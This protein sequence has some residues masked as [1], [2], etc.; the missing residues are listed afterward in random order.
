V[1]I[2]LGMMVMGL[3]V[4]AYMGANRARSLAVGGNMLKISGQASLSQLYAQLQQSRHIYDRG[5]ATD[6]YLAL[7][8]ITGYLAGA[9]LSPG[10]Q[11]TPTSEV[12][13]P[14]IKPN[15]SFEAYLDDGTGV[16]GG[17]ALTTMNGS[18][19]QAS[20]GNALFFLAKDGTIKV[21]ETGT[22]YQQTAFNSSYYAFHTYRFHYYFLVH[23]QLPLRAPNVRPDVN[24]TYQLMHWDSLPF[25]DRTEVEQWLSGL[26]TANGAAAQTF[27]TTK[28]AAL[29]PLYAGA[30]DLG[31]AGA[32]TAFFNLAS[33]DYLT[34]TS[35]T[36]TTAMVSGHYATAI[37]SQ[38]RTSFGEAFVAFNSV[39][40]TGVT[41]TNAVAVP[42]VALPVPAYANGVTSPMPM[43]FEV[44]IAGP[45]QARKVLIHLTMTART[46]PGN[47]LIGE[48]L[49]QI[50]QIYDY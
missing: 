11:L 31:A 42:F 39:A 33:I 18:F 14:K 3:I 16:P 37:K 45:A 29:S 32:N 43:G 7:L 23:R 49:Q 28:L 25:L 2:G 34:L 22:T 8:P 12:L 44:M 10:P 5:A 15:G 9:T 17:Q 6:A 4:Y 47:V 41:P 50:A 35:K 20:V 40:A 30:L 36:A 26:T 1:A 21:Q 27:I 38:F 48:S 19:D 24:W 13:L 46:Q